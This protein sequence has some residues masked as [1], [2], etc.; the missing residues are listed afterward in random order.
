[1]SQTERTVYAIETR[2]LTRRY[3]RLL[4]VDHLSL[5]V[6]RGAL[7]GF[8]GPNGAGKT[9]TLRMLAGLLEPSAGEV[10]VN[11]QFDAPL[12]IG[13]RGASGYLPDFVGVYNDLLVRQY[14]DFFARGHQMPAARRK[15][16]V[17]ELLDL[18]NLTDKR[19]ADVQTLSR[20]MQQRLCLAHAL[21]HDPQILLLD[22]PASGLDPRARVEMRELLKELA[23]M[24]KTVIVSSHILAELAEMCSQVG[25]VEK[26][27]LVACGSPTDI[28]RKLQASRV[29]RVRVLADEPQALEFVRSSMLALRTPRPEGAGAEFA[30]PALSAKS[31]TEPPHTAG[32]GRW[33]GE[34][35]GLPLVGEPVVITDYSRPGT[36]LEM[37]LIG[38]DHVAAALLA[39]MV[40][41]G[42][43]VAG[44]HEANNAL[45]ELF[46]RLT[47]PVST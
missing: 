39:G 44:F 3:G 5:Q 17:D 21:V 25:I 43:P 8:I 34:V 2:D 4:A 36:T 24:D 35:E 6:P 40:A 15:T 26:G 12:V 32:E 38:D 29:L 37:E 18:V 33:S 41:R 11:G 23:A 14:W 30:R 45:E 46:L 47:E 7:F 20:G 9:T 28:R 19:E 42:A 22:E 16:M 13:H 10:W 27:K 1:M 31:P